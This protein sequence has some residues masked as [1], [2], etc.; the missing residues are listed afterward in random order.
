MVDNCEFDHIVICFKF[1]D[2]NEEKDF[3][4]K[5]GKNEV[6]KEEEE[7]HF[8]AIT[9]GFVRTRLENQPNHQTAIITFQCRY[10]EEIV[11]CHGNY[12][13]VI[14]WFYQGRLQ[15]PLSVCEIQ[16]NWFL[17]FDYYSS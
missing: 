2:N 10:I 5:Y 8:A 6:E 3:Y 13:K 16:K 17:R 7:Y 1:I 12:S 11:L 9:E 4:S 15:Q 14:A